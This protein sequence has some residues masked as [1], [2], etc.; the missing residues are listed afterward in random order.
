MSKPP[1]S[2]VLVGVILALAIA[3][4]IY[5]AAVFDFTGPQDLPTE[6]M[7]RTEPTDPRLIKYAEGAAI[8]TGLGAVSGI[9]VG[10]DDAIYV[11][12]DGRLIVF[13]RAGKHLRTVG[14]SPAARC[15]AVDRD[16]TTYLGAADHVQV[17][18]P[19]GARRAVWASAGADAILTCIALTEEAVLVAD[20]GGRRVVRYNRS[21]ARM[22][23]GADRWEIQDLMLRS[24]YLDV[25]VGSDGQI[26]VCEPGE[27]RVNVYTR[28]GELLHSWGKASAQ[29]DGFSGCCNPVHLALL[30]GGRVVTSEKGVPC[31][32][33]YGADDAF[34]CVVAGW[35]KFADLQCPGEQCT[36][37]GALDLATDSRGRVL[38]LDPAARTVRV[39]TRKKD[40]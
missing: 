16:G 18:G 24:A 10:P 12:G 5:M 39:F 27:R 31:V 37:G 7:D 36:L 26:R 11:V 2:S 8:K 40:E 4:A 19:D 3:A 25:A 30:S 17:H 13:D 23:G 20:A 14:V 9:A 21:G 33:V 28:Q 29:I 34:E 1:V 15:L 38:V 6:D 32:K 35:E 22:V